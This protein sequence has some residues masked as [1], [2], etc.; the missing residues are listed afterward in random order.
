M[1]NLLLDLRTNRY[2]KYPWQFETKAGSQVPI[3]F[4]S[5]NSIG[6]SLFMDELCV[7]HC[8]LI[9]ISALFQPQP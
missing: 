2:A 3:I 5:D 8:A 7:A 4:V 1:P 6:Q 9:V